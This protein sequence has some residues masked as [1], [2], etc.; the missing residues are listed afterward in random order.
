MRYQISR[1]WNDESIG[2]LEIW[3]H[4]DLFLTFLA[5]H[6]LVGGDTSFLLY[7]PGSTSFVYN[8]REPK[9]KQNYMRHQNSRKKI[10]QYLKFLIMISNFDFFISR[11][12]DIAQKCF[13]TPDG[14]TDPTF[15]MRYV[16]AIWHVCSRRYQSNNLGDIFFG[17]PCRVG[18]N[19]PFLPKNYSTPILSVYGGMSIENY[20]FQIFLTYGYSALM[21]DK[22]ALTPL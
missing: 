6:I 12:P 1:I 14:A 20:Q 21:A 22:R 3:Y 10:N 7:V 13:C 16:S 9:Y 19:L 2:Y 18:K 8:I 5:I 11:L 4:R 17:T 15:Q